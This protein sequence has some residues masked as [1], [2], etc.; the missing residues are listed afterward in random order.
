MKQIYTLSLL[1][2]VAL[3]AQAQVKK[4]NFDGSYTVRVETE[5]TTTGTASISYVFEIKQQLAIL[6]TT[7]YHEPIRCNG[8]YKAVERGNILTLM[9]NGKEA[10]CKPTMFTIKKEGANYFIKGTGGEGTYN[11]WVKLKKGK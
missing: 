7:T 3:G 11:T 1:M 4:S 9:Y 10:N 8:N 6:T 5:E 2:F